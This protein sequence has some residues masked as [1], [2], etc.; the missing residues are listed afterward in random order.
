MTIKLKTEKL[1]LP[2]QT[3]SLVAGFM[4]W[5]LLSPLMPYIRE[6]IPLTSNEVA[7]VIAVPVILG[8][9]LRI[10]LGYWANRFGARK[11]FFLCFVVLLAPILFISQATSFID[12]LIGGLFLGVGG[13]IFSVGVTALPKYYPK[14]KHGTINAIYAL[15]NL[16]TGITAFSAPFVAGYIGWSATVQLSLFLIAGFALLNFLFGDKH[17][18]KVTT[19]LVDQVKSVYKSSTLWFLCLFYFIT[20]G[21]FV[22]FTVYLPNFLVNHFGLSAVDAG[23]RT[24]G[25]ILL[26]TLI[27]PLGG[28]LSDKYNALVILMFVFTGLTFAGVLLAFMP[29]ITLYT[30]GCLSIALCAGIGNGAIFKLVPHYF[31]KQAGIVNGLVGAMGGL[32]GFFPPIIL[33]V[34]FNITGHYAIGFMALSQVALASLILV[35]WMYFG[36]RLKLVDNA[37]KSTIEPVMVTDT[38]GYIKMVNPAFS[39]ITGYK[40]EEILGKTPRIIKS[41]VHD[42]D[43][44][45]KLWRRI[46]REGYW[47]GE[48]WNRRKNGEKFN[49]WLTITPIK[50]EQNVTIGYVG[51]FTDIN[52]E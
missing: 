2:L 31:T 9:L 18:R 20:F 34:L 48:I 49:I 16:G 27:R 19:P 52:N 11:I 46:D 41:G 44:Y 25:F 8:S 17:E 23:I 32:G 1:Q 42:Q 35:T 33:S 26:A 10:P 39:S 14:E 50:D 4:V 7:L 29:N 45:E 13:A 43:F 37:I 6:D 3:L 24:A 40:L 47:Q 21:A 15:G 5:V 36:E 12:L 28:W 51:M 38:Q 30:I 22:A